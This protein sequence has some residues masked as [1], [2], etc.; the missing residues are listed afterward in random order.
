MRGRSQEPGVRSQELGVG[1]RG[2]V[3]GSRSSGVSNRES[4]FRSR[5]S[6]GQLFIAGGFVVRV[7]RFLWVFWGEDFFGMGGD[8]NSTL[9]I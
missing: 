6:R 4:V 7:V 8:L 2:S 3:V 5:T 1:L 9:W